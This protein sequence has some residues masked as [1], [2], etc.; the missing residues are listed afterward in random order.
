MSK[1]E[2]G[3]RVPSMI[4]NGLDYCLFCLEEDHASQAEAL[5]KE[6]AENQRL[7]DLLEQKATKDSQIRVELPSTENGMCFYITS[8]LPDDEDRLAKELA[9]ALELF[10]ECM[11]EARKN[12]KENKDV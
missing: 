11:R 5:K 1:C 3:H 4:D 2:R 7:R 10:G 9:P 6:K 12:E 8:Y